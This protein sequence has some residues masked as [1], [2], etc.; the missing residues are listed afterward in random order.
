MKAIFKAAE[1]RYYCLGL[2]ETVW[3]DE[4]LGRRASLSNQCLICR[5]GIDFFSGNF[6]KHTL[7]SFQ[8]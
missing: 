8:Y 2:R 7:F 1:A 3:L 4:G 6:L 5:E